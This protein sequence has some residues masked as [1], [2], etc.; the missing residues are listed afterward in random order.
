MIILI[1]SKR[2]T[3]QYYIDHNSTAV[4]LCEKFVR[5]RNKKFD[6]SNINLP[7]NLNL[8][9]N[10]CAMCPYF[11]LLTLFLFWEVRKLDLKF[12]YRH[13]LALYNATPPAIYLLD[14]TFLNVMYKGTTLHTSWATDNARC[15]T[16]LVWDLPSWYPLFRFPF[17][18]RTHIKLWN[19]V[20]MHLKSPASRL[21]TQPF[22][23][24]AVSGHCAG[25]SLVTGEFPAQKASNVENVS[26]R[27]RHHEHPISHPT[28]W[29]VLGV[30]ERKLTLL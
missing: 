13:L 10:V 14:C 23:Q 8:N 11:S 1:C 30:F 17:Q 24:V 19:D 4:M 5:S 9:G 25:N 6:A 27:W 2:I 16:K 29:A 22:I 15:I 18:C 7:S 21:F 26:I 12:V 3:T 28:G 20:I